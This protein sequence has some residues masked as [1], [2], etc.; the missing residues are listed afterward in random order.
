MNKELKYIVSFLEHRLSVS[1]SQRMQELEAYKSKMGGDNV[2]N[3]RFGIP[4]YP[5]TLA[6]YVTGYYKNGIY[7]VRV[8][9]ETYRPL[10]HIKQDGYIVA[11]QSFCGTLFDEFKDED[12]ETPYLT[13]NLLD[14]LKTNTIEGEK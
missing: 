13:K 3:F 1:I 9:D 2:F 10:G 7:K 11:S 8:Q 4:A 14:K 12:R 6:Y 5:Y